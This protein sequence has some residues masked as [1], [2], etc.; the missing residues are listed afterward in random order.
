M[1]KHAATCVYAI[2]YAGYNLCW[3][4]LFC[5]CPALLLLL[6]ARLSTSVAKPAVQLVTHLLDACCL[7]MPAITY[8]SHNMCWL[9]SCLLLAPL[10]PQAE[11][12]RGQAQRA[13]GD[14]P[15]L[16]RLP[17]HHGGSGRH[18]RWVDRVHCM[19][20]HNVLLR[21]RGA[22]AV[23]GHVICAGMEAVDAMYGG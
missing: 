23:S 14:A 18:G 10:S 19:C 11:H 20:M 15:L 16:Q 9:A 3:V 7:E 6:P 22:C 21:L 17:G 4:A 13:G 1:V 2:R 8:A 12:E 5:A